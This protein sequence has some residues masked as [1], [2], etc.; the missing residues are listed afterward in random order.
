MSLSLIP[1]IHM[2]VMLP[3]MEKGIKV[4]VEVINH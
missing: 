4:V 1:S 3:Y 2:L